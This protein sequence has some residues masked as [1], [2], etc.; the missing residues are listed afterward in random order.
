MFNL[1]NEKN[2]GRENARKNGIA[3]FAIIG[4]PLSLSFCSTFLRVSFGLLY[5]AFELFRFIVRHFADF[6]SDMSLDVLAFP[7]QF[8]NFVGHI[9]T[10]E[11]GVYK[12]TTLGARRHLSTKHRVD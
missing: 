6:F 2:V 10:T 5:L 7:F 9:H 4:T 3:H 8:L 11:R 1:I 12:G